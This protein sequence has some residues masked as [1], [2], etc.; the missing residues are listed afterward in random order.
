[1]VLSRSS[2]MRASGCCV[3]Q[4]LEVLGPADGVHD[5]VPV[6]GRE[7]PGVGEG[8]PRRED[9]QVAGVPVRDLGQLL[10]GA[11]RQRLDTE[12]LSFSHSALRASRPRPKP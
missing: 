11:D 12:P 2:T 3:E 10:V 9:E 5:P 4:G 7:G 8:T 6:L 1:M